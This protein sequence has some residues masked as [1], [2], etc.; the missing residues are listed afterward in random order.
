M[1]EVS[2][3]VQPVKEGTPVPRPFS[4]RQRIVLR[5]IITAGYWFIR[6]IGPTLRVCV[7]RE[8]GAQ[9]TI[10]QRPGLFALDTPLNR[11]V[12]DWR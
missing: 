2:T 8:E 6:L 12:V 7:S 9:P 3:T 5:L 10:E 4:L 1:S 11:I